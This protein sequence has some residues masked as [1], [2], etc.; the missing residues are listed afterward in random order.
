MWTMLCPLGSLWMSKQQVLPSVP[1]AV[2]GPLIGQHG[3]LY[4]FRVFSCSPPSHS[5]LYIFIEQETCGT[6][7]FPDRICTLPS[8]ALVRFLSLHAS[9]DT[10]FL[11]RGC[12]AREHMNFNRRRFSSD[13]CHSAL[14]LRSWTG[15]TTSVCINTLLLPLGWSLLIAVMF[16]R[17]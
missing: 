10:V 8:A 5:I 12:F 11:H 7:L 1:C 6:W 15:L 14:A 4:N 16:T 17:T 3:G 2:C 9:F 13:N